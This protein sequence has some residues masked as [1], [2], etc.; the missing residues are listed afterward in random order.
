MFRPP[1]A[2][3]FTPTEGETVAVSVHLAGPRFADGVR[4][5]KV[6]AGC[7]AA[8]AL[9]PLGGAVL[10]A[11]EGLTGIAC[12]LA[13]FALPPLLTGLIYWKVDHPRILRSRH[14][15]E[16]RG[17]IRRGGHPL[18]ERTVRIDDG[19]VAAEV[20]GERLFHG[21]PLVRRVDRVPLPDGGDVVLLVAVEHG[22]RPVCFPLPWHVFGGTGQSADAARWCDA[23][24]RDAR[25]SAP[26][27]PP[28]GYLPEPGLPSVR[29]TPTDEE[30][31]AAALHVR[32]VTG[33]PG[34]RWWWRA[35]GGAVL[36]AVLPWVVKWFP[37]A[38]WRDPLFYAAL[39][40]GPALLVWVAAL[41]YRQFHSRGGVVRA[42]RAWVE[43]D[44]AARAAASVTLDPAGV[45]IAGAG[46]GSFHPW[47]THAAVTET[48]DMLYLPTSTS[49]LFV[50]RR[51]FPSDAAAADFAREA[52]ALRAAA[53]A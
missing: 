23:A 27:G 48:A 21:W 7:I 13:A 37:A 31:E 51:A 26:D 2:A 45:R 16:V 50:P 22:P 30:L 9:L 14:A 41:Q 10:V 17:L 38:A 43:V 35:T 24:V 19:G 29:F 11:V 3:T 4:T 47:G 12:A 49:A 32:G 20:G 33:G 42:T 25:G 40:A 34:L 15:A 5:R 53:A 46:Y 28:G 18:V 1:F 8:V 36:L 52:E 39:A 44:P 6:L